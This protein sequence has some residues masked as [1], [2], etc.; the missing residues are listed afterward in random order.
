[1]KFELP[2]LEQH[3]IDTPASAALAVEDER[4]QR[5]DNTLLFSLSEALRCMHAQWKLAIHLK[6]AVFSSA[7]VRFAHFVVI[8]YRILHR[9]KIGLEDAIGLMACPDH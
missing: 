8:V 1:M 6:L 9:E 3:V 2:I 4:M 5:Q 7:T